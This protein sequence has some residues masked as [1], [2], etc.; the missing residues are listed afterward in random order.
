MNPKPEF[1]IKRVFSSGGKHPRGRLN[2]S[3]KWI[4]KRVIVALEDSYIALSKR[5]YDRMRK[6]LSNSTVLLKLF[7]RLL[8]SSNGSKMFSIVSKTW[9][10]I[11]GCLHECRYCWARRL[12]ETKL[13]N[14]YRYKKGFVPRLNER[15]FNARF[16]EGDF[17]FVSDMGDLFG[18]FIPRNWILKVLSHIKK[19][20]K[21]YFLFLTK[22]PARY[23]EFINELPENVILGATIETDRD[24]MYLEHKISRA[25][26]PSVRYEAL[27][28]IQWDKKF[29]AIE[30][31]LDFN[32]DRFSKWIEDIMPIMVYLGYYNYNNR[33]PEPPLSKTLRLIERL[34][35]ITLLVR[36]TLRQSWNEGLNQHL[37]EEM[38]DESGRT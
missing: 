30:P 33:L 19:F 37:V 21:T 9:N 16:S 31:I 28:R 20:P 17:V 24:E 23:A 18:G 7:E 5:D 11:T 27:R 32:L 29:V 35:R 3:S 10:P 25:P 36:K 38:S 4:G 2:L 13:K 26:L 12:A 8:N 15:E 1:V 14:S 34:S 22:N 6:L